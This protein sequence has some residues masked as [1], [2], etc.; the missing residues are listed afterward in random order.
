[1]SPT[2]IRVMIVDD[3]PIVRNG[4]AL[5]VKYEPG[6][7]VI[8]EVS[9]GH[10]AITFFRQHQP[11]V[12]LMDLRM[13]EIS[14]V[15]TIAAIRQEFP[16][17][18]LIILTTYDSDEDIYRGLQVGAKGYLLKDAPIDE[19]K[20]AIR[21]VYAGK[22]YIPPEVGIKLAERLNNF[23]LSERECEVLQQV[24]KGKSNREIGETLNISEGTVKMHLN[25][26][27][28]KFNASDRTQAVVIALK[29]GVISL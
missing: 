5:M 11:D 13:P 12:T 29:R 24:A 21:V 3:H 14:G 20:K 6:M 9:S 18:K 27:L 25:R 1:M 4:L 16:D 10:E 17:A 8:A 28:S 26:I 23:Q 2:N 15:E 19:I 22:K 7:E